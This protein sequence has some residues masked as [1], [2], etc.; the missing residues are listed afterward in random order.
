MTMLI[1]KWVLF[2]W[3]VSFI[4][5]LWYALYIYKSIHIY[6]LYIRAVFILYSLRKIHSP[7]SLILTF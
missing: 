6:I 7:W 4:Y 2:D 5:L 1:V 3:K